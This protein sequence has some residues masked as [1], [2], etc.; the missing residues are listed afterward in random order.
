MALV[1][2]GP[3]LPAAPVS[4][5]VVAVPRHGRNIKHILSARRVTQA[6]WDHVGGG[7]RCYASW[8]DACAAVAGA[9]GGFAAGVAATA[10]RR[11]P[12]RLA[13][14]ASPDVQSPPRREREPPTPFPADVKVPKVMSNLIELLEQ[15]HPPEDDLVDAFYAV[16]NVHEYDMQWAVWP[17]TVDEARETPFTRACFK[18]LRG[19]LRI[20]ADGKGESQLAAFD[21]MSSLT[22]HGVNLTQLPPAF[23]IECGAI[24]ALSKAARDLIDRPV[25]P[26]IRQLAVGAPKHM[27]SIVIDAGGIETAIS[28]LHDPVV[29]PLDQLDALDFI[30]SMSKRAPAKVAQVGTY[31]AVKVVSNEALVPRRNTIMNLLRPLVQ[32][33]EDEAPKTNIRIGGLK[34]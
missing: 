8:R 31:D 21:L 1:M 25:L 3:L 14:S 22:I 15:E 13:A 6:T 32:Y 4:S 9:S 19:I 18:M 20:I 33:E 2:R 11:R 24:A 7:P 10:R 29:A 17:L 12:L 28:Q 34:F 26:V 27:I 23:A 16:K 30:L 5:A